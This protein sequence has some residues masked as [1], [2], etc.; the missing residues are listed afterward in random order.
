[1]HN[2]LEE[3][4]KDRIYYIRTFYPNPDT[5]KCIGKFIVC[6]LQQTYLNIT[7]TPTL[8]QELF[9]I[10]KFEK[11]DLDISKIRYGTI[12]TSYF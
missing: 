6:E 9:P 4:N 3:E 12:I 1:M 10:Y 2:L 7:P 8:F 5:I 11:F